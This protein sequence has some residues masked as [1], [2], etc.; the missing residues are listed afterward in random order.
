VARLVTL[1]KGWRW[2]QPRPEQ[3]TLDGLRRLVKREAKRRKRLEAKRRAWAYD[4]MLAEAE[5]DS[6]RATRDW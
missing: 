3:P 6:W 5:F 4:A 1:P 2:P